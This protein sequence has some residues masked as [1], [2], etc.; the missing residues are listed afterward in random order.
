MKVHGQKL[1]YRLDGKKG[2]SMSNK[3]KRALTGLAKYLEKAAAKYGT[4]IESDPFIRGLH[5]GKT[6]AFLL[7]AK[8]IQELIP[9]EGV[10]K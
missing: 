7:C 6:D 10:N 5:A 9:R 4:Q 8:W 1:S 2:N 3:E